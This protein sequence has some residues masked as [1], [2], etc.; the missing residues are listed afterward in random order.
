M[1]KTSKYNALLQAP[2]LPEKQRLAAERKYLELLESAFGSSSKVRGAYCEYVAVRSL[3]LDNPAHP[4][5]SEELMAVTRWEKTAEAAARA[6]FGELKI[7]G[8]D[9]HF[10]LHVWNSRTN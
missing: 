10:E 3:G 5:T 9:A 7:A 2:G 1:R 6:V 8:N 4:I